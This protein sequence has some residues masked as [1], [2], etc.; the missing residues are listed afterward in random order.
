MKLVYRGDI[1][2]ILQFCS[3]VCVFQGV[4]YA[5]SVNVCLSV[6][7]RVYVC[8]NVWTVTFGSI[9]VTNT[10]DLIHWANIQKNPKLIV[11][12]KTPH[13]KWKID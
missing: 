9:T 4:L 5:L 1:S 8:V 7:V 6:S 13:Q 2:C 10:V 3:P 11:L 12:P